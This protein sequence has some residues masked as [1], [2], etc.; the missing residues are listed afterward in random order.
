MQIDKR[1]K[2][3]KATSNDEAKE[4]LRYIIAAD[5]TAV[6]TDGKILAVVPCAIGAGDIE[7]AITPDSLTYARKHTLGDGAAVLHLTDDRTAI[8]EDTTSFPRS[9]ESTVK[10][11]GEQLELLRS[12]PMPIERETV[13]LM[14]PKEG[15]TDV[16]V[17]LD[18]ALLGRL[19]EALGNK[20]QITL[21]LRPDDDMIVRSPIRA[22]GH[23]GAYGVLM[24]LGVDKQ[25]EG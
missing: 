5:Q 23:D 20:G 12:D 16:C 18:S 15:S 10:G 9:L 3:E 4:K 25:E 24:P 6:A 11:D 13:M 7:G 8:A 17:A 19:A 22:H 2:I 21:F 1:Y 14:V